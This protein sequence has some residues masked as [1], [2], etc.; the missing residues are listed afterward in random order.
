[1][2]DVENLSSECSHI[3]AS[4]RCLLSSLEDDRV[5]HCQRRTPL[6]RLHQQREVPLQTHILT[7]LLL[8]LYQHT[9]DAQ[10]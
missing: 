7:L 8:L 2:T 4:E 9:H 3:V 6:P 1:M 5:A 10:L